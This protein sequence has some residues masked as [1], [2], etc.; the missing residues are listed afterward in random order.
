MS[1]NYLYFS[2]FVTFWIYNKLIHFCMNK[3]ALSVQAFFLYVLVGW[4]TK[5]IPNQCLF[6]FFSQ[7]TEN[8]LEVL[9][10]YK[11]NNDVFF[12]LNL[13][14]LQGEAE[15]GSGLYVSTINSTNILQLHGFV[16]NQFSCGWH[17]KHILHIQ[18]LRN[19][20]GQTLTFNHSLTW[21]IDKEQ[22]C[23]SI[24]KFCILSSKK[25][26]NKPQLYAASYIRWAFI[27]RQ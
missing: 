8:L 20:N 14:H 13:Q 22:L 15:E 26:N 25:A 3:R 21:K 1:N 24:F 7:Q 19:R 16:D 9:V 10:F 4:L 17:N 23:Q 6:N 18:A 5:G 12:R 2:L 11:L 27:G